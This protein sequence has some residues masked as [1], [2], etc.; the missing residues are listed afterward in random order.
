[1]LN[2]AMS[3]L[4]P[5]RSNATL[6]FFLLLALATDAQPSGM[7]SGQVLEAEGGPAAGARVTISADPLRATTSS[8]PWSRV[9]V[10]DDRGRFV[11]FGVPFHEKYYALAQSPNGY[12]WGWLGA[13]YPGIPATITFR[14]YHGVTE[15]AC[16]EMVATR[17]TTAVWFAVPLIPPQF[18]SICL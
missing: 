10:A 9:V 16:G 8:R 7:V 4:F 11:F 6:L 12:A 1:M 18:P 3:K 17:N 15:G 13:V 14:L 5:M 2:C